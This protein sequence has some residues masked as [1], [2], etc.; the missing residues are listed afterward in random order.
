MTLLYELILLIV[1]LF[2][3]EDRYSIEHL[4]DM[5]LTENFI[6]IKNLKW[7]DKSEIAIISVIKKEISVLR[8]LF[9]FSEILLYI[10]YAGTYLSWKDFSIFIGAFF[11]MLAIVSLI[12][13]IFCLKETFFVTLHTKHNGNIFLKYVNNK[14]ILNLHL[15][16][17]NLKNIFSNKTS[18]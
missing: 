10:Y 4:G 3:R 2:S 5:T 16:N 14:E 8:S 9:M 1:S 7:I 12:F 17:Q 6:A 11:I 15:Q 18:V 13:I